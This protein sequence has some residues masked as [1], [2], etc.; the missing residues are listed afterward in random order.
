M[1]SL[2]FIGIYKIGCNFGKS[3]HIHAALLNLILALV[4]ILVVT[5]LGTTIV[6]FSSLK[7]Y[8]SRYYLCEFCGSIGISTNIAVVLVL[9]LVFNV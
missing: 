6:V 9:A 2:R 7:N 4:L 3:L 8:W 5:Q 1:K